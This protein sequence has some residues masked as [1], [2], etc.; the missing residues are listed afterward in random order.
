MSLCFTYIEK[1]EAAWLLDRRKSNNVRLYVMSQNNRVIVSHDVVL[2]HGAFEAL[3]NNASRFVHFHYNDNPDCG[4][5]VT[6][7]LVTINE[8]GFDSSIKFV[9]EVEIE[10]IIPFCNLDNK[11]LQD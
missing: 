1:E 4:R 8:F 10:K 7:E 2:H 6:L 3:L 5:Q 11:D 9:Y